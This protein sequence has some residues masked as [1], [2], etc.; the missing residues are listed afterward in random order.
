MTFKNSIKY[1]TCFNVCLLIR[2]NTKER[3][4]YK[5]IHVQ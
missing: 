3:N 4:G 2:K 1:D 5:S